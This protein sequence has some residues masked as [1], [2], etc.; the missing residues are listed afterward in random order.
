M[1]LAA[2]R[3]ALPPDRT[4]RAQQTVTRSSGIAA[5]KTSGGL[6]PAHFQCPPAASAPK[7]LR[8][9]RRHPSR[10][11]ASAKSSSPFPELARR[12]SRVRSKPTT[13]RPAPRQLFQR[14]SLGR[15]FIG[16]QPLN[17]CEKLVNRGHAQI[18]VP[19]VSNGDL[20]VFLLA[21]AHDQHKRNLLK[22]RFANF[23]VHLLAAT[24]DFCPD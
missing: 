9:S 1:R 6:V 21:R 2:V 4:I 5:R 13:P 17:V 19:A 12:R 20:P 3:P 11:P 18:A 14:R 22:L 15:D 10:C 24:V 23:K 7:F 16:N 8:T